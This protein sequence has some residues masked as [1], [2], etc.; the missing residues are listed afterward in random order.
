MRD[1]AGNEIEVGK[2]VLICLPGYKHLVWAKVEKIGPKMVTCSYERWKGYMD[3]TPRFPNQVVVPMRPG[4]GHPATA[5][6]HDM[7]P[8]DFPDWS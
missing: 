4:Y 6:S 3:Q 7:F 5:G 8:E 2:D 1:M